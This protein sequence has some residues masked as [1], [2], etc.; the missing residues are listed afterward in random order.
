[1]LPPAQRGQRL[2]GEREHRRPGPMGQRRGP[3]FGRLHR[4]GGAK[5]PHIGDR[6][7]AREMLDRLVGGTVLAEPDGIVVS[8]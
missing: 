2:A 1:M 7:Q 8:T 6:A 4:I 5:D 3:A